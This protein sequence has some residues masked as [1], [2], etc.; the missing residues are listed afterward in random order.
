MP[1]SLFN[2]R[3]IG[4]LSRLELEA[5]VVELLERM[6]A[7]G[8]EHGRELATLTE[9]FRTLEARFDDLSHA[10]MAQGDGCGL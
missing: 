5:A 1:R 2:G 6:E 3:P 10:A 9:R 4:T 8:R 7:Q